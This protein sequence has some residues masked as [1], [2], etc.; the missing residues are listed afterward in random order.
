MVFV[1]RFL[2]TRIGKLHE[3]L[4]RNSKRLLISSLLLGLATGILH[5]LSIRYPALPRQLQENL[6]TFPVQIAFCAL[7]LLS[8]GIMLSVRLYKRHLAVK[9]RRVRSAIR[10]RYIDY[11]VLCLMVSV[12][13]SGRRHLQSPDKEGLTVTQL[14][15]YRREIE[16][17]ISRF[18]VRARKLLY[19][20]PA[21]VTSST[22]FLER[23]FR[24]DGEHFGEEILTLKRDANSLVN[25]PAIKG[26]LD[27]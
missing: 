5:W 2:R 3:F 23:Y 14:E 19:E 8:L 12:A 27:C 26:L 15:C 13:N 4:L 6:R 10:Q 20:P 21:S 9:A 1:L 11:I 24:L 7:S 17:A 25:V 22:P 16:A 18:R